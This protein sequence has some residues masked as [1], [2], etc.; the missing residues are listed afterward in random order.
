MK[1]W[2]IIKRKWRWDHKRLWIRA[3]AMSAAALDLVLAIRFHKEKKWRSGLCLTR[4]L[5]FLHL[6][7]FLSLGPAYYNKRKGLAGPS[8]ERRFERKMSRFSFRMSLNEI[9]RFL[10]LSVHRR[11]QPL[12][13]AQSY[14][15]NDRLM[16][17]PMNE[18]ESWLG[19]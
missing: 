2:L 14:K 4:S 9:S 5:I 11:W 10:W 13:D 17:H 6:K 7:S 15:G 3:Y 19:A 16:A 12:A 18:K 1:S 8:R